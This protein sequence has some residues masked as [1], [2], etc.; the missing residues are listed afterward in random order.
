MAVVA[1]Q[2]FCPRMKGKSISAGED[3]ANIH[4]QQHMIS[5]A[6]VARAAE[7]VKDTSLGHKD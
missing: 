7:A 2:H 3:H 6:D 5:P 1:T 4:L